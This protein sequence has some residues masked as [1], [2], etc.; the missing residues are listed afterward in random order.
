MTLTGKIFKAYAEEI[1]KQ[2]GF[3]SGKMVRKDEPQFLW[4]EYR[5]LDQIISWGRGDKEEALREYSELAAAEKWLLDNGYLKEY[6][7]LYHVNYGI[8]GRTRGTTY[9]GLTDKGWAV[10]DKYLKD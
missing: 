3:G 2:H 9:I 4:E 7:R 5:K 10:A 8:V 6:T 1:V